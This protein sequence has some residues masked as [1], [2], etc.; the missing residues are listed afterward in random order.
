MNWNPSYSY[1]TIPAGMT[2]VPDYWKTLTEPVPPEKGLPHFRTVH[3]ASL[4]ATGAK[5]AIL[6]NSYPDAPLERFTFD[7]I[8]IAAQTAGTIADASNWVFQNTTIQTQ[9][10]SRVAFKNSQNVTGL[11]GK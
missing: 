10:G 3:I 1:A 6:T 9:D 7:R 11:P 8:S 2:N 4:K 5:T